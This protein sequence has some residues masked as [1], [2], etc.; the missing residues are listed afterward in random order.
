MKLKKIFL[1]ATAACGAAFVA[2]SL[3]ACKKTM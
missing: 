3:V 2:T 1:G